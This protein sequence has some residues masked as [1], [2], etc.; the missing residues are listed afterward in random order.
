MHHMR[1]RTP[2]SFLWDGLSSLLR[3]AIAA[4]Q[5]RKQLSQ[6]SVLLSGEDG[7]KQISLLSKS[8]SDSDLVL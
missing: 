4:T 3:G 6:K 7:R 2:E 5:A 1:H 8:G